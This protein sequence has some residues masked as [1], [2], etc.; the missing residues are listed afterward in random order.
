MTDDI[1]YAAWSN[2]QRAEYE[3]DQLVEQVAALRAALRMILA[4]LDGK[5]A[6]SATARGIAREALR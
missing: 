3:N 5:S 4:E 2:A 1:S 6:D